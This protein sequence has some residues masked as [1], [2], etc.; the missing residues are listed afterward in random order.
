MYISSGWQANPG[1]STIERVKLSELDFPA[2]TVCPDWATDQLAIQTIYNMIDF[3]DK[4]KTKLAKTL[5]DMKRVFYGVSHERSDVPR[6]LY[7][8]G[9][10]T[11][12]TPD[13]V[14][15]LKLRKNDIMNFALNN[16]GNLYNAM[17]N[18]VKYLK[19]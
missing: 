17:F 9:W 1:T 4:V 11:D 6:E 8:W 16:E 10:I 14:T 18:K 2:V 7:K 19:S 5:A 12:F 15:N 3:D 13:S